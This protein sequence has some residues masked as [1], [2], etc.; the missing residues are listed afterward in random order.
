MTTKK[1]DVVGRKVIK[2]K[3]ETIT[4]D[5][6]RMIRFI[7]D[8]PLIS[9]KQEMSKS[10]QEYGIESI[11]KKFRIKRLEMGHPTRDRNNKKTYSG[12][13]FNKNLEIYNKDFWKDNM[14]FWLKD[15]YPFDMQYIFQPN[16]SQRNP[17][18]YLFLKGCCIPI[19][20]KSSENGS[21]SWNSTYAQSDIIYMIAS[22][23]LGETAI[24]LGEEISPCE[25]S[26]KVLNKYVADYDK[27]SDRV[28]DKL[29]GIQGAFADETRLPWTVYPRKM[30]CNLT[31]YVNLKDKNEAMRRVIDKI[32][33]ATA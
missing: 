16:G 3:G 28:N 14:T 31:K 7:A 12:Y 26:V 6:M 29:I 25:E 30:Y 11:L 24:I 17:D 32:I 21:A 23:K 9:K 10:N 1:K 13:Y 4:L 19:D 18:I 2:K 8:M 20:V 33:A 27:L 15:A 5:V 22:K